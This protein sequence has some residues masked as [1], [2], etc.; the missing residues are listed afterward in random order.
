MQVPRLIT[1]LPPSNS[2]TFPGNKS[3]FS[4]FFIPELSASSAAAKSETLP[5][6]TERN[7]LT[8]GSN[9]NSL[10]SAFTDA[11]LILT[12]QATEYR[13]KTTVLKKVSDPIVSKNS[14]RHKK[15]PLKHLT[16]S[17]KFGSLCYSVEFA[18]ITNLRIRNHYEITQRTL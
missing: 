2:N 11:E 8:P 16:K 13:Y 14:L 9:V 5:S 7:L 15:K 6:K 4:A 10:S 17:C 1:F 18:K 3:V 12:N